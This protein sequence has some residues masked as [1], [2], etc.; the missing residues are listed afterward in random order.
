MFYYI[1]KTGRTIKD[2]LSEH[3]R[4]IKNFKPYYNYKNVSIHFNL[5]GHNYMNHLSFFIII[6]NIDDKDTRIYFEKLMIY[7]FN[8]NYVKLLNN[9]NELNVHYDFFKNFKFKNFL[10]FGEKPH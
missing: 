8:L 2:R 1:G 10:N 5:I 6:N 7:I 4:D 9:R 3:L